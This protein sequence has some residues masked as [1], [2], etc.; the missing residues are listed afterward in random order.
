MDPVDALSGEPRTKTAD[1]DTAPGAAQWLNHPKPNDESL[2]PGSADW[3]Q[4]SLLAWGEALAREDAEKRKRN[5]PCNH[6]KS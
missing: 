1:A 3:W 5:D 6:R 2:E 4:A